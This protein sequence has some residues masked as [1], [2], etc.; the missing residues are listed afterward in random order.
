M[1]GDI[2]NQLD[3]SHYILGLRQKDNQAGRRSGWLAHISHFIIR[4][5]TYSEQ[6]LK[7]QWVTQKE[8]FS[9]SI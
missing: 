8:R 9:G 1:V 6:I 2:L 5:F 3:R 7:N 4:K